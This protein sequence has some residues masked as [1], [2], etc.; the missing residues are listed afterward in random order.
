M[1]EVNVYGTQ[2]DHLDETWRMKQINAIMHSTT[3][4]F[5]AGG[6]NSLDSS[7]YSSQRWNH[8]VKVSNLSLS[9]TP[10]VPIQNSQFD[11]TQVIK[12]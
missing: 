6:L 10:Y 5:L 7:D 9:I 4:H 2:L 8:I 12:N 11:S 1:G 3:P